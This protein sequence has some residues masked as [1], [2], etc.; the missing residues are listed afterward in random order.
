MFGSKDFYPV[1]YRWSQE[2]PRPMPWRGEQNAYKVWISEIMLQQTRVEQVV[3]Y[4]RAFMQAFPSIQ[5]LASASEQAVLKQWEGLGYNSRARNLHFAAKQVM[6]EMGGVFPSNYADILKLKGIG[7]YTAAAIASF[8]FG[9]AKPVLDTNVMRILTRLFSIE[10]AIDLTETKEKVNEL[11]AQLFDELNPARFNQAIMDFG[12]MQCLPRLP[13]CQTCPMESKCLGRTQG[14]ENLLPIKAIKR[15]RKKVVFAFLVVENAGEIYLTQRTK[16]DIWEGMFTFPE[17]GDILE[18]SQLK[19]GDWLSIGANRLKL[20]H[21]SPIFKQILTH[22]EV[23]A[24]FLK[25][26]P[27]NT[28]TAAQ[29]W[30]PVSIESMKKNYPMPKIIRNYLSNFDIPN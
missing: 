30:I 16:A 3:E 14:I 2:H 6:D 26:E 25:L 20:N 15:P 17:G 11:L 7:P 1:L 5:H 19:I 13:L 21:I 8:A 23:E 28:W 12:A 9:E 22:R 24:V 10:T 18:I 29:S 4:F 27:E